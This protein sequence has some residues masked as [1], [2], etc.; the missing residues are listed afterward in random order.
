MY[1]HICFVYSLK[2]LI[3]IEKIHT[4]KKPCHA[5]TKIQNYREPRRDNQPQG[6][7]NANSPTTSKSTGQSYGWIQ[8]KQTDKQKQKKKERGEGV[9]PTEL[10][11]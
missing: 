11:K 7:K 1:I 4:K 9:R 5:T 8:T 6:Q 2:K 10:S 3:N